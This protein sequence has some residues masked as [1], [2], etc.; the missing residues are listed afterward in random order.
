[1]Y[2]EISTDPGLLKNPALSSVCCVVT[3]I[4]FLIPFGS[5][6]V[7]LEFGNVVLS[8][9]SEEGILKPEYRRQTFG[10]G[11]KPT[12]N[13]TQLLHQAGMEPGL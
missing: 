6:L 3:S 12:T 5:I 2:Y 7:E 11:R 10:A 8:L 1:M 13:S 4:Q 9:N